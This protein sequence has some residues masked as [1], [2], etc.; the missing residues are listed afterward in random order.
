MRFEIERDL[1][2]L[3]FVRKDCADEE[4]QT[5]WGHA[6]VKLE[7][8]LGTSDS[9]Q[10]REPIHTRLDVGGGTILLREHGGCTR[11]LVLRSYW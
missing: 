10:H 9:S 6:V 2:F 7:A 4:N 8:L 3:A 1:L 5:I 11:Y